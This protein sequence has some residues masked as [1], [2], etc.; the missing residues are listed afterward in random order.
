MGPRGAI[1]R[2]Y[3]WYQKFKTQN[4]Y[5][6]RMIGREKGA[7]SGECAPSR[8]AGKARENGNFWASISELQSGR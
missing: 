6:L 2:W 7:E 3:W 8:K 4:F 5:S 1:S